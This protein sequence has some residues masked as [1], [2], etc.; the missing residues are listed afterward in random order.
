MEALANMMVATVDLMEAE[1]RSLRRHLIRIGLAA[2]LL[3]V[4]ALLGLLG[5]GFLLYGLFWL[6]AEQMSNPGAAAA[7][8]LVALALAGGVVWTVHRLIW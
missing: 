5:I 1:G 6:L 4:A 8:G 2:A 3:F 7:L